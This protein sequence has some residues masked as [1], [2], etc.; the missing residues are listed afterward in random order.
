MNA[1]KAFRS[2]VKIRTSVVNSKCVWAQLR[3]RRWNYEKSCSP[4]RSCGS[5][6]LT[7][8]LQFRAPRTQEVEWEWKISTS[9]SAV[10]LL[11]KSWLPFCFCLWGCRKA[12]AHYV[13]VARI[14]TWKCKF[15]HHKMSLIKLSIISCDC[16][17]A[18]TEVSW[19][20]QVYIDRS[21]I[22]SLWTTTPQCIVDGGQMNLLK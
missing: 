19:S 11:A 13:S 22:A 5:E 21:S 9:C 10:D 12:A 3:Q 7:W 16:P 15:L 20:R 2:I 1:L 4:K 6:T 14:E 17:P 18:L 8:F